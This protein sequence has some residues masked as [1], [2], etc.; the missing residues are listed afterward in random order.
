[1]QIGDRPLPITN[2]TLDTLIEE[3]GAECQTVV[4]L[5]HQLQSPHLSERQQTEI[6]SEL[7]ASAIH[8]NVHCGED[9]QALISEQMDQL[10]DDE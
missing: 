4:A 10:P 5:I 8:L 3:L 2:S 9:F 6:L 1:M 7:L